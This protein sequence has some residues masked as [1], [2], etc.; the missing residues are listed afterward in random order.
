M[1]R[2]LLADIGG[3]YARFAIASDGDIGDIWT[4]EVNAHHDIFDAI[5]AF[6][7][8]VPNHRVSMEP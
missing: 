6:F 4:T 7:V 1:S 2:I 3:T 8:R 5:R